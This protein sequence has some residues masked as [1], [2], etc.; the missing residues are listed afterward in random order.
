MKR[1]ARRLL[2]VFA[3]ATAA[4]LLLVGY[5]TLRGST[6]ASVHSCAAS[7][8]ASISSDEVSRTEIE[9]KATTEWRVLQDVEADE[10][11]LKIHPYDCSGSAWLR[12]GERARR[13]GGPLL[14]PWGER[15]QIA[16][17]RSTQNAATLHNDLEII[18]WSKGA[19]RKSGTADDIVAPQG[20]KVPLPR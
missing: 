12:W 19:D 11:I 14:D 15:F 5:V 20:E 3:S 17:R 16:V 10:L 9:A 6:A 13:A 8:S 4:A 7:I 1:G 18:V 2:I